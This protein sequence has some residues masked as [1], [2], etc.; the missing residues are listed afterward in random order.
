MASNIMKS[1]TEPFKQTYHRISG[2]FGY[3]MDI[4]PVIDYDTKNH[5]F[6]GTREYFDFVRV[7]AK[8]LFNTSMNNLQLENMIWANFYR[9]YE[10]D[11]KIIAMNLP[12]NTQPQQEFLTHKMETTKDELAKS[13]LAIKR[14]ELIW[15]ENNSLDRA[16]YLCYFGKTV[17][18]LLDNRANILQILG[19]AKLVMEIEQGE[20]EQILFQFNNMN[21]PIPTQLREKTRKEKYY[22]DEHGEE[23]VQ[24]LIQKKG[25]NPFL[26]ERVGPQG[27][28][29]FKKDRCLMMGDGYVSAITLRWDGS[30]CPDLWLCSLVNFDNTIVTIDLGTKDTETVRVNLGKSMKEQEFR[31]NNSKEK[32]DQIDAQMTYSE[33]EELYE[34]ISLGEVSK[35]ILIRVYTCGRS[36]SAAEEESGNVMKALAAKGFPGAVWIAEGEYVWKAFYRSLKIQQQDR[37]HSRPT[38]GLT[39]NTMAAGNPFYFSS[40]SDPRGT[41]YGYTK[42]CG[43]KV[44][45]DFFGKTKYRTSYDITIFGNQGAGKS[46]LAKKIFHTEFAKGTYLRGIDPTGEWTTLVQSVGGKIISL[47]GSDGIIN[48]WEILQTAETQELSFTNHLEKLKTTYRTFAPDATNAEYTE[49]GQLARKLYVKWGMVR[50]DGEDEDNGI[51]GKKYDRLTGLPPEEYPIFSDFL[52]FVKEEKQSLIDKKMSVTERESVRSH[53][54]RLNMI[55][56]VVDN[57]VNVHGSIFDGYTSVKDIVNQQVVFFNS[58]NLRNMSDE[59]YTAQT[60]N[61]MNLSWQ[62]S[63]IIGGKMKQMFEDELI[64]EEDMIKSMFIFDE[65]HLILNTTKPECVRRVLEFRRQGRKYGISVCILTQEALDLLREGSDEGAN[66]IITLVRLSQYKIIFRQDSNSRD[67]LKRMFQNNI[68]DSELDAIPKFGMGQA[69]LCYGGE[70]N[71][72]FQVDVSKEELDLFRGG[73]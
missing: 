28:I 13:V 10:D 4:F 24:K 18:Q 68:N 1:I 70:T 61:A 52:A 44:I 19:T 57:I 43:G 58:K 55:E 33:L 22:A 37:M 20:K 71:L 35:D 69:L 48:P 59:V 42:G 38:Q 6:K 29:S 49:F 50:E 64:A 40:L 17:K 11:L 67:T 9:R 53:L 32:T 39:S 16:F 62:N 3:F 21:S 60:L 25:K 65:A 26:L 15:I 12:T 2:G 23:A 73:I 46:N 56:L 51:I 30:T 31:Y 72:E 34:E 7:T 14:E 5:C 54:E 36:E 63:I 47:D 8:D 27:G 41:Y 66:Q 45:L